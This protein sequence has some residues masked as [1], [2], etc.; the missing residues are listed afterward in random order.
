LIKKTCLDLSAVL[1]EDFVHFSSQQTN[2]SMR[3]EII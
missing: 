2:I 3:Q 1:Q